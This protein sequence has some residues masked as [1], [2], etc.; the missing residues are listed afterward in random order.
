MALRQDALHPK[1]TSSRTPFA[2]AI[3]LAARR[4]PSS[5]FRR[6]FDRAPDTSTALH[7]CP[8]TAS[9]RSSAHPPRLGPCPPLK[10]LRPF[11]SARLLSAVETPLPPPGPRRTRWPRASWRRRARA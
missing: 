5:A 3:A 8:T 1:T 6:T 2:S 10:L 11:G 4:H 7:P 9:A